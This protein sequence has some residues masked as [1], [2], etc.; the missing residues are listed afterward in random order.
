MSRNLSKTLSLLASALL[1]AACS[2]TP[3][4]PIPGEADPLEAARSETST[5]GNFYSGEATVIDATVLGT[6]TTIGE[7]GPLPSTGGEAEE[8][9][10]EVDEPGLLTASV[11]HAAA[12]ANGN[13]AHAEAS[14]A[15]LSLTVAGNTI[16]ARFLMAEATAT[17]GPN[18]V[19]L[20]GRAHIAN[21]RV[22][23]VHVA[24]TG[25]PNQT[26]TI[27]GV[28][29]TLNEQDA[30]NDGE[31]G[32][33]TVTAL[34]VVVPGVA[35][36]VIASAHADIGCRQVQV[37]A[38]AGDF[39][40]GGGWIEGTP[41]GARGNFGVAG[42]MRKHGLWG[43][44]TYMDHGSR[45]KVKGTEITGYARVGNRATITGRY[46]SNREPSSG[47]FTVVVTDDGEPGRTDTFE[48][49][50][51]DGYAAGGY[52]IGGNIQMHGNPTCE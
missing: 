14:V 28:T 51:S 46:E 19:T 49:T 11:L 10:L 8:T 39:V 21:L 38:G 16:D 30:T 5:E 13:R 32:A 48:I 40:T 4:A 31:Y 26:V 9:F 44:L 25:Q 52:L 3:T 18:G 17:C 42:G 23:G 50:L 6:R 15:D 24:A 29:L 45:L 2:E 36:V 1:L 22:N 20:S 12:V 41:T 47:T 37:C 43:H 34:R 7:V 33:I 27:G 35:E